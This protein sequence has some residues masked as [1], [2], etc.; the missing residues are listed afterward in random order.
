MLE[1]RPAGQFS[2]DA[3][4]A[5]QRRF[6]LAAASLVGLDMGETCF[7]QRGTLACSEVSASADI[8]SLGVLW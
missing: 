6:W 8:G 7:N 1:E 4:Q 5:L 3:V 2:M